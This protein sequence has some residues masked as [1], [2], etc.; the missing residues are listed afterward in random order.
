MMIHSPSLWP[1]RGLPD[2]Q[3]GTF[4]DSLMAEAEKSGWVAVSMKNDW[5][6]IFDFE[7]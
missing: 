2:T 6:R 7:K 5:K 4:P 3:I 1:A